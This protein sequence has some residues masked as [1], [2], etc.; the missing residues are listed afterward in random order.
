MPTNVIIAFERF[1]ESRAAQQD[2]TAVMLVS[3][4]AC[5]AN[6]VLIALSPTFAAAVAVMGPY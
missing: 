5:L 2:F 6:L 1:D 3:L 4:I